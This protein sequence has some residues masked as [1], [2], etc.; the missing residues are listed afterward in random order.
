M[1]G[2]QGGY[3]ASLAERFKIINTFTAKYQDLCGE[4][5]GQIKGVTTVSIIIS[6]SLE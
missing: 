2:F 6:I 5:P 4:Q 3:L 1:R